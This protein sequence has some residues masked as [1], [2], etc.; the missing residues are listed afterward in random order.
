MAQFPVL[1]R[2]GS[3]CDPQAFRLAA[4]RISGIGRNLLTFLEHR[5][6]VPCDSQPACRP[7]ECRAGALGRCGRTGYRSERVRRFPAPI[8][9]SPAT[10][11]LAEL[12]RI[13][14]NAASYSL[15]ALPVGSYTVTVAAPGFH[16]LVYHHLEI[17]LGV[18]LT[19]NARLSLGSVAESDR[20]ELARLLRRTWRLLKRRHRSMQTRSKR[21]RRGGAFI[22][23]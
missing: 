13:R 16:A 8:S 9:G 19:F 7:A 14:M 23:F 18:Q 20:S 5:R 21:W 11:F 17:R 1:S 3:S 2:N 6:A 22:R 15:P 10:P 12:Q 4:S